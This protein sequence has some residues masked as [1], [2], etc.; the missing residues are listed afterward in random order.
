MNSSPSEELNLEAYETVL[1]S[2]FN[3]AWIPP[4]LFD[5]WF[6]YKFHVKPPDM[7]K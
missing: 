4:E 7:L 2:H 3:T 6:V 5:T 1:V